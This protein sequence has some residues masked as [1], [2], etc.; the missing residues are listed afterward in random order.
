MEKKIDGGAREV[1]DKESF[2]PKSVLTLS[3]GYGSGLF[4]KD[5]IAGLTVG[6]VAL[7]LAM[8]FGIASGVTPDKGLYTA[9]VAGFLVSLLGGS[10]FQIG[11]PTGAFVVIISNV[12]Y[13][14]GYDGLVITTLMAGAML[15][16]FGFCRLGSLIK[17]IPHPV[18][19]GFTTGIG[20]LIFSSQMKDFFGMSIADVPPEFFAKWDVYFRHA[21]TL[22]P[23]TL[24]VGC[25]ALAVI[26]LTRRFVPRIPGPVVGVV[27][28]SAAVWA[29]GLDVETIGS[30]FGG[31]PSALP[32]LI[33]PTVTLEQVRVLLPDA[34][35]IALLAGIESLLSCVVADGM[36]GDKHNSNVELAAQGTANIASAFFGGIPATGAIARTVTNIRSGGRTPVAGMIHAAVLAAFILFLAPLASFIP[37]ASLAA[38]LLVVSWDMSEVHKFI[39]VFR[40]PKSD[41]SV[42]LLTFVLTV[43]IDLTVAVYVGVILAAILFMRRMSE[44]TA[45]T[46]CALD[47]VAREAGRGT[48]EL[49]IPEG[50][51]VYEIDGPFFFGVADRFQ[52]VLSFLES[53]PRVFILR[54]RKVPAVDS[55]GVNALENFIRRCHSRGTHVVMSGVRDRAR[56]VF[57]RMGTEELLGSENICADIDCALARARVLLA[58]DEAGGRGAH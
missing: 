37:L 40:A 52:D 20:V 15:L 39:R 44:V 42:M 7:P 32:S 48:G 33:I 16:V 46:S 18:T 23:V 35:T 5:F 27:L 43:V 19:T 58:G 34:M 13:R 51:R 4:I 25:S 2:I 22:S 50:V 41:S 12:I 31:I 28:A 38:V 21:S 8:A 29:F 24:S 3:R 10:K 56:M 55:S 53:Q 17:Y 30:R 45:I 1:A 11:G 54:M 36:T 14:H 6:I 9:I 49:A 26:I 57:E 47:E